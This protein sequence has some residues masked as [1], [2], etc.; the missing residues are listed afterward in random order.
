M[1]Y[2]NLI[3]EIPAGFLP[4][5]IKLFSAIIVPGGIFFSRDTFESIEKTQKKFRR[6][7]FWNSIIFLAIGNVNQYISFVTKI[8]LVSMTLFTMLM[9]YLF[10]QNYFEFNCDNI[11][12]FTYSPNCKQ[13][14][15]GGWAFLNIYFVSS[16]WFTICSVLIFP[17]ILR[18]A[19]SGPAPSSG[20]QLQLQLWLV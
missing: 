5:F 12:P 1:S 11:P 13:N 17:V 15:W 3:L 4:F 16:V 8:F 19:I 14:R 9:I 18:E 10:A 2:Q 6:F 20:S 7:S